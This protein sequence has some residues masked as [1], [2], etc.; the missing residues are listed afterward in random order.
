MIFVLRR[1][2]KIDFL[3]LRCE[4]DGRVK[5]IYYRDYNIFKLRN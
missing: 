4:K 1:F 5:K 3:I 2:L